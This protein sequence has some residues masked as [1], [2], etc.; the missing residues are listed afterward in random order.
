MCHN[1]LLKEEKVAGEIDIVHKNTQPPLK[2]RMNSKFQIKKVGGKK[3]T[4]IEIT[5]DPLRCLDAVPL[6]QPE[7]LLLLLLFTRKEKKNPR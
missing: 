3:T 2:F 4:S 7:L 5:G 6:L 1:C